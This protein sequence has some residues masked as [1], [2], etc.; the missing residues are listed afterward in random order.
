M[1][2]CIP[3]M[4]LV[5]IEVTRHLSHGLELQTE[6]HCVGPEGSKHCEPPSH[7]YSLRGKSV[8]TLLSNDLNGLLKLY[9]LK[10]AIFGQILTKRKRKK[11]PTFG[12]LLWN[13]TVKQLGIYLST[14]Y[15]SIPR[16]VSGLVCMEKRAAAPWQKQAGNRL[17]SSMFLLHSFSHVEFS[18]PANS[19]IWFITYN[20]Y[21]PSDKKDVEEA[22]SADSGL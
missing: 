20:S 15:Q 17:L 11:K 1:Y 19:G 2:I 3:L 22:T 16:K 5:P 12:D 14:C 4:C 18:G 6:R 7:P 9:W 13:T 21:A 10:E 8:T